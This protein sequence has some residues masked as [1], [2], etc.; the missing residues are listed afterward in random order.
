MRGLL[1]AAGRLESAGATAGTEISRFV[2]PAGLPAS[3]EASSL[4]DIVRHQF[5]Q[6]AKTAP[7]PALDALFDVGLKSLQ[8]ANQRATALATPPE[9]S[10][11]P[12]SAVVEVEV[13]APKASDAA[14]TVGQVF[15]H[16]KYG[17]RGVV[18]GWDPVCRASA[19]WV[20]STGAA[21]LP[22]GTDQPFYHCLVDVRDRPEAQ[23]S[24][25][26]QDNIELLE[27]PSAP[28]TPALLVQRVIAHPLLT[29]YFADY[30]PLE[31]A[32]VPA[33]SSGDEDSEDDEGASG[34]GRGR[35]GTA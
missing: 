2:L 34:S 12:A 29:R 9:T 18:I 17:Y 13:E 23:V 4:K 3:G 25:V 7:G 33:G 26:A 8:M 14:F 15:R 16:R 22:S 1:R 30:R 20:S 11:P 24:Y 19:Q 27:T 31:G 5:R 10:A 21:T 28:L 6:A 35:V 32:Y